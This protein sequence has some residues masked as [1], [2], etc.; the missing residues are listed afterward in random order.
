VNGMNC[1]W[2]GRVRDVVICV[3]CDDL[4]GQDRRMGRLRLVLVSGGCHL[5]GGR[6]FYSAWTSALL[7]NF[8]AARGAPMGS[9]GAGHAPVHA[10]RA[11]F[12]SIF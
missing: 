2:G 5:P 12:D 3:V 9:E 4:L 7:I 6:H 11:L 1:G 10:S 8:H